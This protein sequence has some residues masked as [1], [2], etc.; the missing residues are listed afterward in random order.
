MLAGALTTTGGVDMELSTIG[1][2]VRGVD[3]QPA[4]PAMTA[5]ASPR[6]AMTARVRGPMTTVCIDSNFPMLFVLIYCNALC[7]L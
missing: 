7:A 4:R 2:G 1:A 5:A 3:V 6:L